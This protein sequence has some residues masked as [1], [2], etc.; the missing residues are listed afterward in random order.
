[1]IGLM[2]VAG[3]GSNSGDKTANQAAEVSGKVSASG[4]TALLPLL[5]PAQEEFHKM[6][7]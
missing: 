6:Y 1:M 5:K 2:M 3:C 7:D 4:S